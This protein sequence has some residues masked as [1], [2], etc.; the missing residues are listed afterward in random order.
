MVNLQPAF[1]TLG[2]G[3][4]VPHAHFP[5]LRWPVSKPRKR[6][7]LAK[8][9]QFFIDD[10]AAAGGDDQAAK[11]L[12]MPENV[13]IGCESAAGHA[14]EMKSVEPQVFHQG[15]QIIRDGAWLRTSVRIRPAAA[16]SPPIESD[17]PKSCLDEACN[18]VLPA[19]GVACVRVEQ[20][21]R[22]A[23]TA[24]VR[25]PQAHAREIR[26]SRESCARSLC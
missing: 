14:D 6:S 2:V 12:R 5:K 3:R 8:L 22:Y 17:N 18:V 15:V 4:H 19:V 10:G 24:A 9:A 20:Y 11:P 26:V 25:V 13:V 7:I 23:V 21:D 1:E 16:P